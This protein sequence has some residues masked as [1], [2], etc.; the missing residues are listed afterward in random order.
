MIRTRTAYHAEII[1]NPKFKEVIE[2]PMAVVRELTK[3]NFYE[4]VKYF[5]GLVSAHNFQDN[6]HIPYICRELEELALQV[7]LRKPRDHD[8]IIN[9]PPG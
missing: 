1:N 4:F 6:W 8:L 5:W 9:V 7:S 2:N 3:R